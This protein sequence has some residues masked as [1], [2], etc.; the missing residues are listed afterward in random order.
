MLHSSF[1]FFVRMRENYD[2][3]LFGL[4]CGIHMKSKFAHGCRTGAMRTSYMTRGGLIGNAYGYIRTYEWYPI[5][6]SG[7]FL[8]YLIMRMLV[9]AI[10]THLKSTGIR[11][12]PGLSIG[13]HPSIYRA[14]YSKLIHKQILFRLRRPSI[15]VQCT[16][17]WVHSLSQPALT[18]KDCL[19]NV[20]I[21]VPVH[22]INLTKINICYKTPPMH[23]LIATPLHSH[24]NW[25]NVHC[26]D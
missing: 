18:H 11:C 17:I 8:L 24:I 25:K 23:L 1:V 2:M 26:C 19:R 5:M 13:V 15:N 21:K 6:L 9:S 7:I 22:R 20:F 16:S 3:V 4:M 10:S 14:C 12:S